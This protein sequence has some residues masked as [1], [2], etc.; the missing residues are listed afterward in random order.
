MNPVGP[1]S[2]PKLAS[3]SIWAYGFVT[4]DNVRLPDLVELAGLRFLDHDREGPVE[5]PGVDPD[6]ANA[7]IDQELRRVPA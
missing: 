2:S 5:A 4:A 7:R 1:G 3:R 6:Q